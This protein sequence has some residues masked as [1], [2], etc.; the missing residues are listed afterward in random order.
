M[1]TPNFVIGKGV[2]HQIRLRKKIQVWLIQSW[3]NFW[4]VH[5]SA[6][7]VPYPIGSDYLPCTCITLTLLNSIQIQWGV[8]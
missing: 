4:E 6:F 1:S 2:G 5:F 7:W 8:H 3:I